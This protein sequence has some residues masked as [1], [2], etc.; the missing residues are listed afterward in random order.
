VALLAHV[1]RELME[2]GRAADEAAA[3]AERAAAEAPA[4]AGLN[5]DGLWLL[6][7]FVVLNSADRLAALAPVLEWALT[8]SRERGLAGA[9]GSP[10]ACVPRRRSGQAASPRPRP[11]PGAPSTSG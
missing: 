11:R 7:L 6:N 2:L 3:P 9:S 5:P 10:P 1:A 4:R 8:A